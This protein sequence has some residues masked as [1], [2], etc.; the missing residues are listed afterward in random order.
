MGPSQPPWVCRP[1]NIKVNFIVTTNYHIFLI[2]ASLYLE[3]QLQY[4]KPFLSEVLQVTQTSFP[5][6]GKRPWERGCRLRKFRRFSGSA[7]SVP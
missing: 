2:M 1:K 4:K 3:R 6:P 5:G 7:V